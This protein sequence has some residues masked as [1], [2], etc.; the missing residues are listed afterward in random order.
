MGAGY[1]RRLIILNSRFIREGDV[2]EV[3][4]GPQRFVGFVFRIKMFHTEFLDVA[5]NHR[6]MIRNSRLQSFDLHNL[7]RF[8]SAKG[9]REQLLFKIDYGVAPADVRS[10]F[11]AAFSNASCSDEM[12]FERQ[13]PAEVSVMDTGDY[14]VTWALHYYIK[15]VRLILRTRQ[16]MYERVLEAATACGISLATPVLLANG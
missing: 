10:M 3:D 12:A 14:A 2:V 8:A 1:Y 4:E 13:F 5:N 16:Q 15:D 11:E 7:N 6:I 9:L